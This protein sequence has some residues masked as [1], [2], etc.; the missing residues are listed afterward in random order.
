[1]PQPKLQKQRKA[2][3]GYERAIEGWKSMIE[4][5]K[6]SIEKERKQPL[7]DQSRVDAFQFAIG[8][9]QD[10][11]AKLE[12]HVQ[13]TKIAMNRLPGGNRRKGYETV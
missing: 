4:R 6:E 13:L 5:R 12:K 9:F 10:K 7:P 3:A 8:L 11:I 1:M 2:I